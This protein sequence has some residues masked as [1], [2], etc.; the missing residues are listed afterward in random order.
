MIRIILFI[1]ACILRSYTFAQINVSTQHNNLSRT[2]E[3]T[4][5]T[6]LNI[7]NVNQSSFGK[8]FTRTV[9]DQIYAQP[10]I[11]SGV[12]I[13][14]K[15]KRNVVFV[16]TVN[17]SVYAFDAE[18]PAESNFLWKTSFLSTG[19][20]PPRNTDMTGACGG[21]YL[22]FTGNMGIVGTPV[23]DTVTGILYVVARTKEGT[24]YVQKLHGL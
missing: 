15:G 19:V 23:I 22:D 2:G 17:N 13:P 18:T 1:T 12:N 24:N 10:L 3:N 5:E 6:I 4:K 11:I 21:N 16:A 9:D 14:G 8:I 7:D 20:V